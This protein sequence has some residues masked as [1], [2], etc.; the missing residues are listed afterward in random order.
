M[1]VLRNNGRDKA[2]AFMEHVIWKLAR[3]EPIIYDLT[4]GERHG[5]LCAFQLRTFE[6]PEHPENFL[7]IYILAF[8]YCRPVDTDGRIPAAWRNCCRKNTFGQLAVL[9]EI[10]D[11]TRSMYRVDQAGC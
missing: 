3:V 2:K 4:V 11:M 10:D 6:D 9:G 8:N 1:T 5:S 7:E